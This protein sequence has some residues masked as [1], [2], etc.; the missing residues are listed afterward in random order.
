MLVRRLAVLVICLAATAPVHAAQPGE[1]I[2]NFEG[3]PVKT[4]GAAPSPA[5]VREAIIEAGQRRAWTFVD[6]GPG[7]LIA[8]LLV[9]EKHTAEVNIAYTAENYSLTYRRSM[10]LRYSADGPT[11]H[12]SYNKWVTE[13]VNSI[14]TELSRV[15]GAGAA[16]P[17]PPIAAPATAAVAAAPRPKPAFSAGSANAAEMSFWESVRDS[18][19]P[20]ELQ[21]YLDAY[22]D[23]IFAPLARTRLA[24]LKK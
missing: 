12:P 6:A 23:G 19:E 7:L 14:N 16:A 17:S 15:Q 2:A 8:T 20:S 18:K 9:R 22:P 4:L 10:N 11:I 3:M 5:Q 13:F 1:P 24:A 21:A